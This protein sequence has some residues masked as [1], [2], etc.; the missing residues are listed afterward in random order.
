MTNHRLMDLYAKPVSYKFNDEEL[1]FIKKHNPKSR[2][3][4]K[5]CI[6]KQHSSRGWYIAFIID[7]CPTAVRKTVAWNSFQV[8]SERDLTNLEYTELCKNY[9]R[10]NKAMIVYWYNGVEYLVYED[11]LYNIDTPKEFVEKC[12]ELGYSKSYQTKMF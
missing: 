10:N 5:Y 2:Y 3:K 8:I 6:Y 1:S 9:G 12:Q 4:G 7:Q 11:S